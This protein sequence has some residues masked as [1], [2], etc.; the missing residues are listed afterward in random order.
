[1]VAQSNNNQERNVDEAVREFVAAQLRGDKPD[2]EEL[3]RQ[4]PR[5]EDE[6]KQKIKE[7][8]AVDSLLA[9]LVRIGENEFEITSSDKDLIGRKIGSFEITEMIGWGGMGIVYLAHD[10]KLDR[11][12]AIKSMPAELLADAT[13]QAR[14]RREATLLASLSH[15]GIAV[16]HDIIEQE[17]TAGY[18]VL[19]YVPGQ[20]LAERIAGKPLKLKEA[21][22]IAQQIAEAVLAAHEKGI[23]H[24]DLKPGNI[25]IT[26]EGRV[27]I[28]DFGLAKDSI[29]EAQNTETAITQPGRVVGTP[30]YMSPEQVR[31]KSTDQRSD[32][33][34]FGCILFEMLTGHLAFQGE[35]A[36]DIAA[37]VLEREPDW[38]LLPSGT[39]T[40]INILLRRCLNKD[41][42]KRLRDIGDA[43]IEII[44]TLGTITGSGTLAEVA[45]E[46]AARSK[47]KPGILWLLM[48][49]MILFAVV[50]II[51]LV[52]NLTSPF[53]HL[54]PATEPARRFAVTLPPSQQLDVDIWASSVA[55]APDGTS[56]V[57]V[58]QEKGQKRL[59]IHNMT[60]AFSPK[61]IDGTED[62]RNPF[63]SPDG[64]TIAFFAENKLKKVSLKSGTIT[65][66]LTVSITSR[67]GAWASDDT[68]FFNMTP[69]SG[70]YKV[71]AN[72]GNYEPVTRPDPAPSDSRHGYPQIL[73]GRNA[74]LL[75][76]ATGDDPDQWHIVVLSLDTGTW[77]DLGL[78][79][80]KACYVRTGHLVYAGA[81]G[82]LLAVPFDLNKLEVT[83]SASTVIENA[84]TYPA[85]HFCI[86]D[87]GT[88][89]YAPGEATIGKNNTLV[90]VDSRG[91]EQ[92]LGFPPA[93]YG[94][95]RLSPNGRQ[96]AVHIGA[97]A[98]DCEIY[99]CDMT[100]LVLTRLT[101]NPGWDVRPRWAP[102]SHRLTYSSART[103]PPQL[104]WLSPD[105]S[106]EERL[107]D[108]DPNS[109]E[110][111]GSWS[112]DERY[113][114]FVH[115]TEETQ[116]DIWVVSME[117]GRQAM[118]F[119]GESYNEKKPAFHPGGNWIAYSSD[120][121]GRYEVYVRRFPSGRDKIR[122]STNGGDDPVWDPSG[123]ALYYRI[124]NKM[125]GVVIE[126]EPIFSPGKLEELFEGRYERNEWGTSYDVANTPEGLRFI[127]IK[128]GQEDSSVTQ[129]NVIL[130]WCEE[131]K[132][133]V[134]AS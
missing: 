39:P 88:L 52:K 26:P 117:D 15:P 102:V 65:D 5:F 86:S 31:G 66:I 37:H 23:I 98:S 120:E 49:L 46:G 118:E 25:K 57:Y 73:P 78:R 6:I 61:P 69:G 51:F 92:P 32:I 105:G 97:V 108:C 28:L 68:I 84:I 48:S 67:G 99:L 125:M 132:R 95:V 111:P 114:A 17:G 80:S 106:G 19:E 11:V 131:L 119:L 45:L 14:F 134:P 63:L 21:L 121:T 81:G 90:S 36:S 60:E 110:L 72:G 16:I 53:G 47:R 124:S 8:E 27:K 91:L 9:S 100:R 130:N 4:Y 116:F 133:L 128:L 85:A 112:S 94:S 71:S 58:A 2:I 75:T 83:G 54:Q 122:I 129:L 126:T 38:E 70:L 104:Y 101:F 55:I 87:N 44:D 30:A 20:T 127:M 42:H 59:Y 18:L 22:S 7:F 40:N 123:T 1:M 77:R 76:I 24:R 34:S 115:I 10:T 12:V 3:I 41:V 13:A 79:G 109:L 96:L 74:I 62:A 35:T 82:R 33:W 29:K 89:V 64:E 56:L 93:A 43:A 103:S 113:F 107:W 50:S